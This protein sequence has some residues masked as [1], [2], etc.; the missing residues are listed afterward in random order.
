MRSGFALGV[1]LQLTLALFSALIMG[2]SRERRTLGILVGIG[3]LAI[4]WVGE[5]PLSRGVLCLA[6]IASLGRLIDLARER[7]SIP[8]LRR[9]WHVL[10]P[11]DSWQASPAPSGLDLR[12][13][14]IALVGTLVAALG[15]VVVQKDSF[16][17]YSWG[18]WGARW[19]GGLLLIYGLA[20]AVHAL[21]AVLYRIGG[22]QIPSQ[23]RTPLAAR[24]IQEFW[25]SR[26]NRTVSR[27][28]DRNVFRSWARRGEPRSGWAIAFVISALLHA[29]LVLVAV[30]PATA[31]WMGI[32]FLLQGV[33]VLVEIR[34][35]VDRWST[36]WAHGWVASVMILTSPFF[37]EPFLHVLGLES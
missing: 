9:L 24:S 37:T 35:H 36:M 4:P 32:Y 33:L 28:L 16:P 30:G 31:L 29:Y 8:A 19:M 2:G 7:R 13:L 21:L 15:F 23:H 5:A 11:I 3:M 27:W 20:D 12:A 18:Y 14:G 6:A 26:W 10:S 34:L 17:S 25:G 22:R 1:A